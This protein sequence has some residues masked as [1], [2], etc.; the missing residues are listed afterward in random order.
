MTS[1][2][3]KNVWDLDPR[4]ELQRGSHSFKKVLSRSHPFIANAQQLYKLCKQPVLMYK[5]SGIIPATLAASFQMSKR[6]RLTT[7]S[8][9]ESKITGKT[10]MSTLML[11]ASPMAAPISASDCE[12]FLIRSRIVRGRPW[13][14]AI[15][16]N[17]VNRRS[18]QIQC[19]PDLKRC[20]VSEVRIIISLALKCFIF[21]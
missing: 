17:V 11:I 9:D 21:Y 7:G 12:V 15:S 5:E 3:C 16:N 20:I 1:S 10:R 19:P 14:A 4:S 6:F 18:L 13:R 2:F 8:P